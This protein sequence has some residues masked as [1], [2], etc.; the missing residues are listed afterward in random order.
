MVDEITLEI[1]KAIIVI[2]T[3]V[4]VRYL[5]PVLIENANN[6]QDARLRAFVKEAVYCAE[7][8]LKTGAEKKEFVVN[9]VVAW[10]K[11]QSVKVD[12]E[13]IEAL[14]ESAVFAMN[15]EIKGS[16]N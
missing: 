4:V 12:K 16:S 7:Q 9:L 6:I 15:Q 13:Q 5:V 1:M 3:I 10:L 14:I 8:I 11:S 2:A